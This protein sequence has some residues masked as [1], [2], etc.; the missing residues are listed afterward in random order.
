MA[1]CLRLPMGT[2]RSLTQRCGAAPVTVHVPGTR[3]QCRVCFDPW[4]CLHRRK[5]LLAEYLGRPQALRDHMLSY[6]SDVA[7]HITTTF[8]PDAKLS[9]GLREKLAQHRL[10][11][12][13][14]T[15]HAP[16]RVLGGKHRRRGDTG[17]IPIRPV[18][19]VG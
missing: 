3:F 2:V 11:A 13:V 5:E 6:V 1:L 14:P 12:W 19:R 4:P 7:A 15:S 8:V 18:F 16:D 10:T 17:P 9:S